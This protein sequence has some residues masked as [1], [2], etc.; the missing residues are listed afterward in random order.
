MFEQLEPVKN[1]EYLREKWQESKQTAKTR[2]RLV[3]ALF[4]G[5]WLAGAWYA[6]ATVSGIAQ[7]DGVVRWLARMSTGG[8][9]FLWRILTF[10]GA[11]QETADKP[12]GLWFPLALLVPG[13][14]CLF[15]YLY[16]QPP[17]PR[18]G[19]R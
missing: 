2:W 18:L 14:I 3:L 17:N 1:S 10:I 16:H 9:S 11:I 19:I 13:L 5:L 15:I 7:L 8:F 6:P 12:N 4:A